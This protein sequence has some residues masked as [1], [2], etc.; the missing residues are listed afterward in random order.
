[1]AE[2]VG[3]G[4]ISVTLNVASGET[5]RVN[6][7]L[8]SA[9]NDITADVKV[10][11]DNTSLNRV[12]AEIKSKVS[13]TN[14]QVNVTVDQSSL[15]RAK[16]EI[17][18]KF[19]TKVS[20]KV[21]LDT[22]AARASADALKAQLDRTLTNPHIKADLDILAAKLQAEQLKLKLGE[23][24]DPHIK[25]DLDTMAARL[26]VDQL[27]FKMAELHDKHVEVHVDV[28][29]SPLQR[30]EQDAPAM[31]KNTGTL[32]SGGM[33]G[34]L[35]SPVIGT[36]LVAGIAA[37]LAIGLPALGAMVSGT[38]FAAVGTLGIGAA[39]FAVKDDPRFKAGLKGIKD[40]WKTV[41]D[42]GTKE[43]ILK[44][45]L[46]AMKIISDAIRGWAPQIRQLL[47]AGSSFAQSL[48]T[49]LKMFVDGFIQP[50]T[51]FMKSNFARDIM[52][53]FASGLGTIGKALGDFFQRWLANPKAMEGAKIGL[54]QIM[55]VIA[56]LV[57]F[58]GDFF[59]K[60]SAVWAD[61]N[62]KAPGGR[63]VLDS[64]R[65]V[66]ARMFDA[67]LI[68][69]KGL[70]LLWRWFTTKGPD[71][72]SAFNHIG[73]AIKACVEAVKSMWHW[74]QDNLLPILVKVGGFLRGQLMAAFEGIKKQILDHKREFTLL[75]KIIGV[76]FL[77]ALVGC[78][79][80][81]AIFVGALALIAIA[82][83]RVIQG[84]VWF[85]GNLI[86]WFAD[87]IHWITN[88][89]SATWSWVSAFFGGIAQN[90]TNW[91]SWLWGQVTNIFNTSLAW[92]R[93][94]WDTVWNWVAARFAQFANW[95]ANAVVTIW[96][97]IKSWFADGLNWVTNAWN[98]G[99]SWIQQHLQQWGQWVVNAVQTI[100]NAIK[101][102]FSE[103]LTWI[104]NAWNT[105]FQAIRDFFTT[106]FNNIL[107]F[108]GDSWNTIKDA[109]KQGL[110]WITTI[111]QQAWEGV[112]TFFSDIWNQVVDVVK[113]GINKVLDVLN[114]GSHAINGVMKGLGISW[115][116]PDMPK[117]ATGGPVAIGVQPF[118]E[119][120]SVLGPG[121]GTSDSILARLSNGEH[122]W[123]AR[124]VEAAGGQEAVARLRKNVLKHRIG[125]QGDT[126]IPFNQGGMVFIPGFADGGAASVAK[127]QE[128]QNWLWQQNG[129]PYVM[130]AA[131][132]DAWDCSGLV[133]AVRKMVQGQSP[134][135]RIFSTVDEAGFFSP[136]FGG[137]NDLNAGW[138]G[139]GGGDGHT[140]GSIG[141][142]NFEATPP[143]VL[144]G[145]VQ[146]TPGMFPNKGHASLGGGSPFSGGGGGGQ[147]MNQF[148][149]KGYDWILQNQLGP[150][151]DK[152]HQGV[153]FQPSPGAQIVASISA[154]DQAV[155]ATQA[156][157]S[158]VLKGGAISSTHDGGFRARDAGGSKAIIT[159]AKQK[160]DE[161]IAAAQAA[162]SGGPNSGNLADVAVEQMAYATAKAMGASDKV[163]LALFE[164]GFVESGF[165]NLQTATDHDSL[166]FLQ[167][168]PSAGWPSPLNV[169]TATRS[170]V[171]RAMAADHGGGS[172][173]QLAQAVQVSAFPGRYD[174]MEAVARAAIARVSS[175]A[176]ANSVTAAGIH[177][178]GGYM[179]PGWNFN[180]TG[181]AELA[182]N[183]AQGEALQKRIAGEDRPQKP[184][185]VTVLLD[186]EV[187]ADRV[188]TAIDANNA[189]TV[190]ALRGGRGRKR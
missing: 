20:Q 81:I 18:G 100:W 9:I 127:V 3:S 123:T 121:S 175:M 62:A 185:F 76:L 164:A 78:V 104:S 145:N 27:Q 23:I 28:D 140:T 24:R 53:I 47:V 113:G 106:I 182:L 37:A 109:F 4:Y 114:G 118:W 102:W 45:L 8:K 167:Q 158:G 31:G 83:A 64:I 115:N 99:F 5:N 30:L 162:A 117:L 25:A 122:V 67:V 66:I 188:E 11:L 12:A 129:K 52:N 110:D 51:N 143:H 63:S 91:V 58:T 54:K 155:K 166:G 36:V 57:R 22:A 101:Q 19:A 116:I 174:A 71:G 131:G 34:V 77:G 33:S 183:A 41:I 148:L 1:M 179:Q 150:A 42:E 156:D 97:A 170:F 189:A 133:G 124:E 137:V 17:G 184:V 43:Q 142:L 84:V 171:Q 15:Q 13:G 139:G 2:E 126:G 160:I 136:G 120:G 181:K 107:Q 159:T 46:P 130:G 65:M 49:G 138:E 128:I 59:M 95:I 56:S 87:G 94:T 119:G 48:A 44:N 86:K 35:S 173:G 154:L 73:D 163:I 55:D 190:A 144:I 60:M 96:N 40:A 88:A 10:S 92:V 153:Q 178:N 141:G 125:D 105:A 93:N 89:W 177:D 32:F 74:F 98:V 134:Y 168:R 111:W 176:A 16:T 161:A 69:V 38:F 135:G 147:P 90:L 112:K 186:G 70:E 14:A 72:K 7:L 50:L 165:R 79:A 85:V 21:D 146:M 80:I 151:V 26:Q 61:L 39:I 132:P 152:L 75:A 149:A 108:L 172:A 29:K 157:I 68:L 187:I 169:P 103:G 6:A 180:G 82:L